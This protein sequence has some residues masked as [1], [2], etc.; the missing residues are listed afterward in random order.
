MH[1][2][3]PFLRVKEISITFNSNGYLKL[4]ATADVYLLEYL[5]KEQT[6]LDGQ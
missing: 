2:P 3:R 4:M 5:N 1:L 6:L